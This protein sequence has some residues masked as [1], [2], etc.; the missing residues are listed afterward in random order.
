MAGEFDFVMNLQIQLEQMLKELKVFQDS[1]DKLL[2]RNYDVT[3]NLQDGGT[4]K[5]MV[6][7]IKGI[8]Q[9]AKQMTENMTEA[10]ET[11]A[12]VDKETGKLYSAVNK[13]VQ[14]TG[15]EV[16]ALA[17]LNQIL[18]TTKGNTKRTADEIA[19]VLAGSATR[20]ETAQKL[21]EIN[22]ALQ[23]LKAITQSGD[24]E[25]SDL[26]AEYNEIAKTLTTIGVKS[27]KLELLGTDNPIAEARKLSTELNNI[28]RLT[29]ERAKRNLEIGKQTSADNKVTADTLSKRINLAKSLLGAEK[30]LAQQAEKTK[31]DIIEGG[32]DPQQ[33]LKIILDLDFIRLQLNELQGYE[34]KLAMDKEFFFKSMR[35]AGLGKDF[36]LKGT[37]GQTLEGGQI[38]PTISE[39]RAQQRATEQAGFKATL[40]TIISELKRGETSAFDRTTDVPKVGQRLLEVINLL[41]K[42]ELGEA[43]DSSEIRRVLQQGEKV[44]QF[45]ASM[46]R[47]AQ[48]PGEAKF[49]KDLLQAL[50]TEFVSPLNRF[51]ERLEKGGRPEAKVVPDI[52][53]E[54]ARLQSELRALEQSAKSDLVG[55]TLTETGNQELTENVRKLVAALRSGD[56][57]E[58]AQVGNLP[59]KIAAAFKE[60]VQ[61]AGT[62][63]SLVRISKVAEVASSQLTKY[64]NALDRASSKLANKEVFGVVEKSME[65]LA[66]EFSAQLRLFKAQRDILG[67]GPRRTLSAINKD[68]NSLQ[69]TLKK[70]D[71]LELERGVVDSAEE[72]DRLT[73]A[74]ERTKRQLVAQQDKLVIE[75]LKGTG[76]SRVPTLVREQI[77]DTQSRLGFGNDTEI[78]PNEQ[79]LIR[80][81]QVFAEQ[82]GR[83][84]EIALQNNE[85]RIKT[86]LAR[87]QE[88]KAAELENFG[89]REFLQEVFQDGGPTERVAAAMKEAADNSAKF[90]KNNREAF[91]T[92]R[93]LE[94]V[95]EG[96]EESALI[97]NR[98]E[99]FRAERARLLA[100]YYRAIRGLSYT[101]GGF[102]VG[103]TAGQ[104]FREAFSGSVQ[105]E[106]ELASIQGILP[107][108]SQADSDLLRSG[109]TDL[110][111]Q[112]GASLIE[113]AQ[114]A[115][116]LA[117]TGIG[118]TAV[119]RELDITLRAQRGIGITVEQMQEL[120]IAIRAVADETTRLNATASVLDKIARIESSF[121]I[122]AAD[123]ADAIKVAAPVVNQFAGDMRG[124]N[125]VFDITIGLSTAM[126]EQLRITG[127]QAGNALKFIL[128]RLARPEVLNKLQDVYGLNIA[129]DAEGKTIL[130]LGDLLQ[131]I[132]GRYQELSGAQKQQFAVLL[133][134]GRRVNAALAF[135][136]NY[137][138]VLDAS[139]R[140]SSAFGDTQERVAINLDTLSGALERLSA[141]FSIFIEQLNR[142]TGIASG[143]QVIVTQVGRLLALGEGST[144]GGLTG[145]LGLLGGASV[146]GGGARALYGT[147]ATATLASRFGGGVKN[148]SKVREAMERTKAE[149]LGIPFKGVSSAGGRFGKG[150]LSILINPTFGVAAAITLLVAALGAA[151]NVR[152]RLSQFDRFKV[153][154]K[155]LDQL[156]FLES[157]QFAQLQAFGEGLGTGGLEPTVN[158]VLDALNSEAFLN[159]FVG[160][161]GG[162][163]LPDLLTELEGLTASETRDRFG[164]VV[165]Q[166]TASFINELGTGAKLFEEMGSEAERVAAATRLIG[167][168]ALAA[169]ASVENLKTSITES[170]TTLQAQ[171]LEEATS[172]TDSRAFT[173]PLNFQRLVAGLSVGGA[174]TARGRQLALDQE[175]QNFTKFF[176]DFGKV[177]FEGADQV[178]LKERFIEVFEPILQ[179]SETFGEAMARITGSLLE[180]ESSV[181]A[182]QFQ[183]RLAESIENLILGENRGELLAAGFAGIFNTSAVTDAERTTSNVTE[184]LRRATEQARQN[185]LSQVDE[186]NPAARAQAALIDRIFEE[187]PLDSFR[188]QILGAGDAVG[189]F[190][191]KLLE[192]LI[193]TAQKFEQLDLEESIARGLGEDFDRQQQEFDLGK[194]LLTEFR[195][196]RSNLESDLARDADRLQILR[197]QLADAQALEQRN[198]GLNNALGD[199]AET[200]TIGDAGA[201][202]ERLEFKIQEV[203]S[204][205]RRFFDQGQA[206]SKFLDVDEADRFRR[207]LEDAASEFELTGRL[208]EDAAAALDELFLKITQTNR[209]ALLARERAKI[210]TDQEL[211]TTT[212]LLEQQLEYTNLLSSRTDQFQAQL[213]IL[214][215]IFRL[216]QENLRANLQ[217]DG[218]LSE[219]DI[220]ELRRASAEFFQDMQ[221]RAADIQTSLVTGMT[222]QLRNNVESALSGVQSLISDSDIVS[223]LFQKGQDGQVRA[224]VDSVFGPIGDTIASRVAE[225][226]VAGIAESLQGSLFESALGSPETRMREEMITGGAIAANMMRDAI[227]LGAA[228]AAGRMTGVEANMVLGA[229][230]QIQ[231]DAINLANRNRAGA[232]RDSL[233]QSGGIVGGS[234]LG[235][236]VARNQNRDNQFVGLL[237]SIGTAGGT[238]LAG[239]LGGAILGAVGGLLGGFLGGKKEE[240]AQKLQIRALEA[241]E[242]AQVE[243]ISTIESQTNEL[244]SPQNRF[245]N[246]PTG[247]SV[248]NFNPSGGL[249]INFNFSGANIGSGANLDSLK[250][251]VQDAVVEGISE[252]RKTGS[253]SFRRL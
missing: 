233:L 51:V 155:S 121:A 184:L 18:E 190:R 54:R 217:R 83:A 75:T 182:G 76:S 101:I 46:G 4:A 186:A 55:T 192:F 102:A 249:Q 210:V 63:D 58:L 246:V 248:P 62:N 95:M 2:N 183:D 206:L 214:Q 96:Q 31:K 1:M 89:A 153:S 194:S 136:D 241:I 40:N 107:R 138:K 6:S 226:T 143:L 150:I 57:A 115:R 228:V 225:N 191:D 21:E 118:A 98:I 90:A 223:G 236:L 235:G 99:K 25:P 64:N 197:Q 245:I 9:G 92:M 3:V 208:S 112:Y 169:N 34:I 212:R 237:S 180:T 39:Q 172:R 239:P 15:D 137:E 130:P 154:T 105:L 106:K 170:A 160:T 177:L 157:T 207:V 22:K 11:I 66:T 187:L 37:R 45:V 198:E 5:Q 124:L 227:V 111:G 41:K 163:A 125:D 149:N 44:S 161:F 166:L 147:I 43:V 209:Q 56:P 216:E 72:F 12:K 141:N 79:A 29:E 219:E 159:N 244:L 251:A 10:S 47:N 74:I 199:E 13:F 176:G 93:G 24:L 84:L 162:K 36:V 109:I 119:M 188:A 218:D 178:E 26:R 103:I 104:K 110:S 108:R 86:L 142:G 196:L 113:T 7:N 201:E 126:V 151:K 49:I 16:S 32:A 229:N 97:I 68:L 131:E 80:L 230:N 200:G 78:L 139:R 240:E 129:A 122:T 185:L 205:I 81:R 146:V 140:S 59:E 174:G 23:S 181:V 17:R 38:P 189:A 65:D 148:F 69:N 202:A 144:S 61:G 211:A 171:I 224:F 165:P 82:F 87:G 221:D 120:Q 14:A 50:S 88:E 91:A 52:R 133:A 94:T 179:S 30:S 70:L 77:S 253:R 158:T 243:T 220:L 250:Q 114:A 71:L 135:L 232:L 173:R 35:E 42:G 85:T 20:E 19:K 238:A 73:K 28:A 252:G 234:L 164:A 27:S 213:P 203:S 242:R 204:A 222:E 247:F 134:G 167:L 156:G 33:P 8:A 168:A 152:D 215:E 67:Q 53:A 123:I 60:A 231:T 193:S 48:T 132:V 116:I 128:A 175:L 195:S 127:N 100:G 145:I 117:Q